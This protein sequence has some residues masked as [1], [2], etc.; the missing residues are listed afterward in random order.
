MDQSE[1]K[2]V[3]PFSQQ[4][5]VERHEP[6]TCGFED[7][8]KYVR[9]VDSVY[10]GEGMP[11]IHTEWSEFKDVAWEA[12]DPEDEV[13]ERIDKCEVE[14]KALEL[15]GQRWRGAWT[16]LN[17]ERCEHLEL[18]ATKLKARFDKDGKTWFYLKIMT[19]IFY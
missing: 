14:M 2:T 1:T 7:C 13:I 15:E 8:E 19:N 4:T 17:K 5:V 11:D 18:L 16:A 6:K 3:F 9:R 12:G 10:T